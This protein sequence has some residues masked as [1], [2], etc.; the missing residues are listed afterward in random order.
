MPRLA[1]SP[2]LDRH[3]KFNVDLIGSLMIH[4]QK[5]AMIVGPSRI[6]WQVID[7]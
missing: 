4:R 5:S 2:P 6:G 3:I 7:T 1:G